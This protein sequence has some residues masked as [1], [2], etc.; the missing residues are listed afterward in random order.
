MVVHD[1]P[2]NRSADPKQA[3]EGAHLL[4]Q[5]RVRA[6]NG[7]LHPRAFATPLR[8]PKPFHKPSNDAFFILKAA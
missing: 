5:V 8:R 7:D 2:R 3:D 4:A 6:I 1:I